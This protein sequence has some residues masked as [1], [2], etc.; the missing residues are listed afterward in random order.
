MSRVIVLYY[1]RTGNT[2]KMARAVAEGARELGAEV[3]VAPVDGF[4]VDRLKEFDGIVVGSPV[5]YGTMAAE[6]K[7]LFDDSV[8]FHGGLKG[9]VG[10]AFSSSANLAGGNET[11]IMDILQAML[12]HGMVVQGT[13]SGD[14]YGPVALGAPDK[15]AI[16]GCRELGRRVACLAAALAGKELRHC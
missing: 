8:R 12:I 11:T 16:E 10:G 7:K 3:E 4:K 2:E 15:R 9:K 5:Y 13:H 14:H 6:V 1:S